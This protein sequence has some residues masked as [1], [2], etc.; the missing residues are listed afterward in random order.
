MI[1]PVANGSPGPLDKKIPCRISFKISSIEELAGR[2][3]GENYSYLNF[4]EY[5]F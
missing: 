5:F 3:V 1:L 2:T 4:E